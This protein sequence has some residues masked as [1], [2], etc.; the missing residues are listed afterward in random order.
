MPGTP[1]DD[2]INNA[3]GNAVED[4]VEDDST[5]GSNG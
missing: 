5:G 3:G 1:A 2:V 4:P